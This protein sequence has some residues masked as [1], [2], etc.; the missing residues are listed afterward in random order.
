MKL[1]FDILSNADGAH[2]VPVVAFRLDPKYHNGFDEFLMAHDLEKKGWLV[3]AYRMAD[4]ASHI[5]LLRVV[6]RI[7]FTQFLCERFVES[8]KSIL[9]E[10]GILHVI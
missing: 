4:G 6:C 7:D 2:G 1:G 5:V 8:V 9:E 10:R 3:P